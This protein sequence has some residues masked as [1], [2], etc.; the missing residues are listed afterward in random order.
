MTTQKS[1]ELQ[2]QF[3][4]EIG[5]KKLTIE[6]GKFAG[7]A[8]GSCTVRYGDT[9]VLA[10]AVT[11]KKPREGIDFFPLLVDYEEKLYAA[12]KIKGSRFIKRETKPSDEAFLTARLVD[13]AIRP[14]FDEKLR[15]D[16]QIVLTV[17]SWDGENDADIPSLVAASTALAISDIPWQGPIAAVRVGQINGEWVLN[18]SYEAR[19][20]SD[21]D[22]AIAGTSERTV[23]IEG[24][25]S[26]IKEET[27]L[28]A[29]EFS[30]KH[31]DRVL[32]LIKEVQKEVGRKKNLE[33]LEEDKEILQQVQEL[34]NKV[35]KILKKNLDPVLFNKTLG[36]K[37]DRKEVILDFKEKLNEELEFQEVGKEKR[38]KAISLVDKMI[39][40]E[41]SQTILKKGKR[42]DGRGLDEIRSLSSEVALLPHTH[43]SGLF[44]RGQTQVL[45]I[46]T[47]G[48]PSEEQF[49]D[50]MELSGKKS[51]MHHYNFPGFSV[52]EVAPL[53][54]PG[55]R[56]IGHG[57]LVEKALLPLIPDKEKFPYT[58]RVVSE[59]LS[60]N[61]SSSMASVCGSSLALMDAG[62]PIKKSI[63][64]IAIGLA[65]EG[66][67]EIEKFKIITDL[68]D[69][70]DGSGGMDFKVAGTR[71][72]ITVIQMDT[73]TQGLTKEIIE[74]TLKKAKEARDKI[75]DNMEKTISSP[76]KEVSPYAPKI[77]VVKIDPAKIRDVI[78]PGGR[79]INEI[80]DKT[81][82]TTIDIEPDG[83]VYI[84]S[85]KAESLEKAVEW[86]KNLTREV[87]VGEIFQ[88]KVVRILDFGAFVEILPNQDGLVHIS[89]LA[90]YHV[91]KVEDIVKVGDTVRVKI[92]KV[93]EQGRINLSLKAL[94][95]PPENFAGGDSNRFSGPSHSPLSKGARGL[96]SQRR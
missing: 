37:E 68:Q 55:R 6:T 77:T 8:N 30:G 63:A 44:Q 49:L 34:K 69:L 42:V 46:V 84:A 45:S 52:G 95:I 56:D 58:I 73:K 76:R 93:D 78:G 17:L 47:L 22:L 86:V 2:Q 36:K 28:K 24:S 13:R 74:E 21:L 91:N 9:L 33:M 61:G 79:V 5:G 41:V 72:G 57:A 90:H 12:G 3:T 10:T 82:V 66:D 19:E 96:S 51:F 35:E 4:T 26:E 16:V 83:I 88:G 94:Q 87:K 54:G 15:N 25:G 59:V 39:E 85:S 32:K 40:K 75:L 60:S 89:E 70:E 67:G 23:M 65:S 92:I 27:V 48:A 38:A 18:P 29:I 43:G 20:K 62:V 71:D 1:A 11:K 64:G 50:T 81:G 31:I 14:F 7:Q 80:I 53:R